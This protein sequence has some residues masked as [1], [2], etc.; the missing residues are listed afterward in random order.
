MLSDSF[1]KIGV[2]RSM[3]GGDGME[4]QFIGFPDIL[5]RV[6]GGCLA[7]V[8]CRRGRARYTNAGPGAFLGRLSEPQHA[9]T[10]VKSR[11]I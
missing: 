9:P 10:C 2:V 4:V 3:P 5:W 8:V 1:A 11:D 6:T 7:A